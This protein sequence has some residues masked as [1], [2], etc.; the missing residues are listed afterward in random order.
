M[1]TP[2]SVKALFLEKLLSVRE[3]ILEDAPNKTPQQM[4]DS[5]IHGA[6]SVVEDF[7]VLPSRD[8]ETPKAETI[9]CKGLDAAFFEAV[10]N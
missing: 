10:N 3:T 6:L 2:E 4:L 1:D 5:G 7:F 9:Y 8:Y